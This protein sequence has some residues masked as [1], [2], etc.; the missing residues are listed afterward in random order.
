MVLT[1]TSLTALIGWYDQHREVLELRN[2]MVALSQEEKRSDVVKSISRQMEEIAYQQRIISDEQREEAIQQK[3]TADEMRQRSEVER[4]KALVAEK[5]AVASEQQAQEA[6]HQAEAD[7]QMAE[8]QRVQA[9]FSK[10]VTDTLSYVALG[11]SLG[12]LSVTQSQLGNDELAG[13]LAY[14]SFRF[15][16]RYHGDIYYPAVFQSLMSSSQSKHSWSRH[17]G[18]VMGLAYLSETDNRIVTVSSY[19]EIMIHQKKNNQLDSKVLFSDKNFDFRDVYIDKDAII[20]AVC[21]EGHL[22]IIDKDKVSVL[23]VKLL[24]HPTAITTLDDANMLVI[25][26]RGLALYNKQRHMITANRELDFR[27][28]AHNRYNYEPVLFDDRGR[29]HIVKTINELETIIAPVKGQVTAFASSKNT[30]MRAYGMIDGTI[31]LFNE[32][33]KGITKLDGHLSRISKLKINGN[34]LFSASYDGRM[35][36]WNIASDKIEPMTLISAGSWIMNFNFDN[37]KQNAWIGDQEGNITEALM[38]VPMMVDIV[39]G[40]LKRDFTK[41]EWNYYIGNKVPYESFLTPDR[42]EG[43]Q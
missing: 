31:Y 29:Q 25:G 18:S 42:K 28:T 7:R 38:S 19:G 35:N 13:L 33:T 3:R 23:D 26:E 30:K 17:N 32:R 16:D 12:A 27:I 40:K 43:G 10:R 4:Q 20:Y 1:A 11:R 36:F 15:T 24:P 5:N 39:H 34:R 37:S 21:R 9:E 14:A 8:H 6:R 2:Q 41:E 22:V